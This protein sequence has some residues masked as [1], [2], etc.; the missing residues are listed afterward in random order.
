[1]H[2]DAAITEYVR[3]LMVHTRTHEDI[4]RG[5]SPRVT[6][7]LETA[8]RAAGVLQWWLRMQQNRILSGVPGAGLHDSLHFAWEDTSGMH[9]NHSHTRDS[10]SPRPSRQW[11]GGYRSAEKEPIEEDS[12]G[13][14]VTPS[15]MREVYFN[16]MR[17]RFTCDYDPDGDT[18]FRQRI[19]EELFSTEGVAGVVMPL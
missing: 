9:A 16:V 17:H 13:A 15:M 8:L 2:L 10:Y 3:A 5:P 19:L 4:H 18:A 1:V 7:Q 12:V 14:F 6:S 11:H